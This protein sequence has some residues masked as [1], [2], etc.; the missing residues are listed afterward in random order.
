[1]ILDKDKINILICPLDWGL[2]HATRCVPI[3][4]ELVS[5]NVNVILAGSGASLQLLKCE[6]PQLEYLLLEGYNI[7]YPKN[8]SMV[9]KMFIQFPAIIYKIIKEHRQ[10]KLIIKKHSID[11]VISDNRYGLF[12]KKV[13]SIFITHQIIIKC[14][15]WLKFLEPLI[16]LLNNYF[17]SRYT[18]CWIPDY[19]GK[20]NLSGSLSHKYPRL[21]KTRF[22]GPQ[23][24]FYKTSF[25]FTSGKIIFDLMVIL[26]GPEPQRSILENKVINQLSKLNLKS[27]VV[28]GKPGIFEEKQIGNN[29]TLLSCLTSDEIIKY[30][31]NSNIILCRSGYSSIMDLCALGKKAILVPTPGQT[32]QEYL[33]RYFKKQKI[34]YSQSQKELDIFDAVLQSEDYVGIKIRNNPSLLNTRL[35]KLLQR[36]KKN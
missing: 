6:F 19:K 30:M 12:T 21:S 28:L 17:I 8:R 3:I 34:F 32:E 5:R 22:I 23:S 36:I 4:K 26:S 1:M 27:I 9:L 35:H 31:F 15:F 33:A 10:L 14:P 16:F 11:A 13:P 2:G 18:E 7:S 20:I 29:I 25:D 24:R